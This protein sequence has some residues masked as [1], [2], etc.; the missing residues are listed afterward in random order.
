MTPAP[1]HNPSRADYIGTHNQM[2]AGSI[3]NTVQ[4]IQTNDQMPTHAP[5]VGGHHDPANTGMMGGGLLL[6]L[7]LQMLDLVLSQ[8]FNYHNNI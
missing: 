8:V 5:G 4:Q 3:S 7:Q 6:N 2:N 1:T